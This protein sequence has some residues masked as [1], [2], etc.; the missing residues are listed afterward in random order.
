MRFPQ[1]RRYWVIL[2]IIILVLSFLSWRGYELKST[3]FLEGVLS[4]IFRPFQKIITNIHH[5]LKDNWTLLT[6]LKEIKTKNDEMQDQ[7]DQLEFQA[8]EL[9][10]LKLENRRLRKLLAFKELISYQM[11]GAQVIGTTPNNWV[12]HLIIDRGSKDGI[13]EKMAVITYNGALVGQVIEVSPN[14]ARVSLLVDIDF[15]VSARVQDQESRTIG[16][17]R[18]LPDRK[19]IVLMDDITRAAKIKERDIIVT[20]GLSPNFPKDI[21]IGRVLKVTGES[22]GMIQQAEIQPFMNLYMIEEVLVITDF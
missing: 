5:S 3:N 19:D 14:T 8:A 4:Q 21:P 15:A 2:V 7:I 17:I 12:Q 6:N 10:K 11:V 22:Y 13:K 1:K 9:N 20:S 16:V 18:G